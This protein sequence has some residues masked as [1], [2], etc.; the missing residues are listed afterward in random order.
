MKK[1]SASTPAEPIRTLGD[2]I[3]IAE[4]TQGL[5]LF[6]GQEQDY[7]LRPKIAR[8]RP[9]DGHSIEAAEKAMLAEL[10]RRAVPL[11]PR[12]FTNDW[13]WLALAQHHGMATRLLDCSDNPLAALWFAVEK[14]F[15]SQFDKAGK[16]VGDDCPVV[17]M[18]RPTN[19]DMVND[20]TP[21]DPFAAARTKV[22][23]PVHISPRIVAQG[24]WFTVHKFLPTFK[25]GF[26][27]LE[28]N[29]AYKTKLQKFL[30]DVKCVASLRTE[31]RRCGMHR[32]TIYPGLEGLCGQIEESYCLL[33][34]E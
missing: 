11:L 10:K 28:H 15:T 31:L 12:P 23:R 14:P 4:G 33:K 27:S 17:W 30:V 1:K 13:D 5:L 21:G 19:E 29:A 16:P 26:V 24:G 22:F 6:R 25:T 7:A 2:Y 18:F 32:G 9:R 3:K 8:L 20:E 34:D